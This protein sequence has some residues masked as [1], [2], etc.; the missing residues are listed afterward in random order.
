MSAIKDG[1]ALGQTDL[2]TL[3]DFQLACIE[4]FG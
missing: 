3:A 2:A 4:A 1:F